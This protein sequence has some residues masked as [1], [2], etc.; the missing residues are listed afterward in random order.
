LCKQEGNVT[1]TRI[2]R[3]QESALPD[4]AVFIGRFIIFAVVHSLFAANRTKQAFSRAA[5]KEPRSYRLLY[6]LAS[7]AMF[8]WVMAAYRT[9]PL[10]Y[11][12]PG[13]GKWLLYMAQLVVAVV[14][15]RCVCQTGSGDF[16]GIRQFRT[17]AGQPHRL[18]TCGYYARVRHPLYFFSTLFLLLNPVMTGQ[19]LLLTVLSVAYFVIGGIIE[20]S[21][22]LKEFGDQ[23]RQYR[24][25]VPFMIPTLR[26]R[27][28]TGV[29]ARAP[30]AADER[31]LPQ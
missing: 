30:G 29:L 12:V 21:R 14:L 5:G 23:Y 17:P 16:L 11:A 22:L 2:I 31:R 18:V 9:S 27:T 4:Y 26:R 6:N 7:L 10:L 20:E 28:P 15:F 13:I 19:W 3:H 24:L 1:F 8:A 25:Q